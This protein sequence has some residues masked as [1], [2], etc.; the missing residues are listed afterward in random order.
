MKKIFLSCMFASMTLA[1]AT[2]TVTAADAASADAVPSIDVLTRTLAE[3][4]KNLTALRHK[5]TYME[6][7]ILRERDSSGK[8]TRE[9]KTDYEIRYV[10]DHTI[11]RMLKKNGEALNTDEQASEDARVQKLLDEAGRTPVPAST[12]ENVL[13]ATRITDVKRITYKN[14]KA[15][16]LEFEPREGFPGTRR[17][18]CFRTCP[19][20]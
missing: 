5:Y 11:S 4:Q 8:V 18:S 1:S 17:S 2:H 9:D 7:E 14:V 16:S 13:T 12:V 10:K 6:H 19:E 15:L 3:K 20:K